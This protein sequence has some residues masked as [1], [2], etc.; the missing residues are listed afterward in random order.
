MN[1]SV[2]RWLSSQVGCTLFGRHGT[3]TMCQF[4]SKEAH[5]SLCFDSK[6][7]STGWRKLV[8]G[9]ARHDGFFAM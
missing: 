4:E 3:L 6:A 7:D 8:V 9:E 1:I 2:M 5:E